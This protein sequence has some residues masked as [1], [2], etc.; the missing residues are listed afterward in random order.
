MCI[1]DRLDTDFAGLAIITVTASD[2]NGGTQ[3]TSFSVVVQSGEAGNEPP[4]QVT[5]LPD[6]QFTTRDTE[7]TL[8][9]LSPSF[10][11]DPDNDPLAFSAQSDTTDVVVATIGNDGNS[12]RLQIINPGQATI[13]VTAVDTAGQTVSGTFDVLVQSG[14][15]DNLPPQQVANLPDQQFTT[16]DTEGTLNGLSPSFFVDPNGDPLAFSAQSS[17]TDVVVASIGNDGN[18]VRMQLSLIHI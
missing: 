12:V 11:A 17:A 3:S 8:N 5:A 7:G 10:F 16:R 1:R 2:G 13:T 6:Q 15:P 4:Q 18:S 9:G 14:D